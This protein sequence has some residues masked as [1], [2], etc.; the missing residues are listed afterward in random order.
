MTG[1][2]P[3]VRVAASEAELAR[4]AAAFTATALRSAVARTGAA[5]VVMATG[6]SQLAFVRRLAAEEIPWS[7]VTVFHM[8]EYIGIGPD[9]PASFRRWIR[10]H[11]AAPFRP[12]AVHYIDG[13][14]IAADECDRYEHLLRA[15]PIDLTCMGIGENGH[16]A[17]NEPHDADFDDDRW[18][19][20]VTLTD[21]SIAQQVGEG[22]FATADDVPRSAISLT[23]PALLAASRVQ[24]VVPEARKAHAVRDSLTAD[25]SPACPATILRRAAHATLFLDPDSAGLVDLG[26]RR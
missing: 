12:R 18:V 2:Y 16:L 6:N 22:H 25:I 17:F 14:A 11:V 9:H 15:A 24:V 7:A 8:D 1:E 21:A 26:N 10:D 13:D 20:Q 19:R 3:A 5:R 4:A 23:I